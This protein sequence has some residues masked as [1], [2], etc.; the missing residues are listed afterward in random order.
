MTAI[1]QKKYPLVLIHGW[2][3]DNRAWQPLI[4]YLE[5]FADVQLI[6]LPGFGNEAALDA[7]TAAGLVD[8]LAQK[9][10]QKSWVIGWSLGGMLA[11]RLAV[12][13]PQKVAGLVTL[14]ANAKF[15]AGDGYAAAMPKNINKNF[16]QSFL[17]NPS[18][19]LKIFSGLVAQGALEERALLKKVR[20]A[21]PQEAVSVSAWYQA[22]KLLSEMDNREF[23]EKMTHPCLHLLAENDALVPKE[24]ASYLS[25]INPSGAVKLVERAAHALHW[26]YPQEIASTIE[27]FVKD[28]FREQS[29][30]QKVARNFSKAA[31][32]Y[33]ALSDVQYQAGQMLLQNYSASL[34]MPAD[35]QL[36]DLGAGTGRLLPLLR[37]RF[38]WATL[39]AVD[40]SQAMLKQSAI[41]NAEVQEVSYL[42][43]DAEALPVGNA[44]LD[45]IYS[46]FSLQWCHNLAVLVQEMSR[47]L[48]KNGEILITTLVNGSLD[49]LRAAWKSVDDYQ[50]VNQFVS[51]NDF[52]AAVSAKF[53]VIVAEQKSLSASFANLDQLLRSL[54]AIGASY[55]T[56]D[57]AAPRG[58][59]SRQKFSRLAEAY[60]AFRQEGN[61]P[62]TYQV[63][64]LRAKKRE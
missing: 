39:H 23:L 43:A 55:V 63:L 5:T 44:K 53:D 59:A 58:L 25:N 19:S 35:A 20:A 3:C 29:F 21:F 15:V 10:R 50:H 8:W 17:D 16:N 34:E 41:T 38:P 45:L 60:E 6:E 46:N 40:I 31:G 54:K 33:D 37:K 52:V 27:N 48:K 47:S 12:V 62:L 4:S 57:V 32:Q 28:S 18:T 14:A 30:K 1:A 56:T 24:A 22:L 64:F 2:G 51:K 9:I 36:M 11:V 42:V 13:Y 26:C 61:L 49:E 7:Y